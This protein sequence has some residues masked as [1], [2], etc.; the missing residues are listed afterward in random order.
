MCRTPEEYR[1]R[2]HRLNKPICLTGL[3]GWAGKGKSTAVLQ[4]VSQMKVANVRLEY[5]TP[6][7]I[8]VLLSI[9]QTSAQHAK[10]FFESHFQHDEARSASVPSRKSAKDTLFENSQRVCDYIELV[11][12][13]L[14]FAYTSLEAFANLSIPSGYVDA[15]QVKT[16]GTVEHYDKNAIERWVALRDKLD[17]IL[18]GIY[19]TSRPSAQPFWGLFVKLEDYRNEIVHQKSITSTEFYKRYFERDIFKVCNSPIDVMS[20][21]FDESYR[22]NRTNPLWPW[23]INR[24]NVVPVRA[25]DSSE[26]ELIDDNGR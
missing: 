14:V 7:N 16:R 22:K 20:F 1:Q 6:N 13:C 24:E 4:G 5:F 25:S 2:D 11:Q 26:I 21:F 23:L 18:P 3:D 12:T 9:S 8:A 10:A 19:A 15:V 17:S